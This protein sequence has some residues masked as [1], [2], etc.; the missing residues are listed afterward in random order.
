MREVDGPA[1]AEII[2]KSGY[3]NKIYGVT[4]STD[5]SDHEAF[6]TAGA[7]AVFV[8]PLTSESYNA[9]LKSI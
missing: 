1:A 7:D 4:G 9:I 2:R 5:Q 3:I 8:K 6:T